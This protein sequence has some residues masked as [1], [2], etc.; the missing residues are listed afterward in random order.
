V[1]GNLFAVA[2]G[3]RYVTKSLPFCVDVRAIA[4]WQNNQYISIIIPRGI[5]SQRREDAV[6]VMTKRSALTRDERRKHHDL[7]DCPDEKNGKL[8]GN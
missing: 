7:I 8:S 4:F 5:R 1:N 3:T 6:Q 2:S